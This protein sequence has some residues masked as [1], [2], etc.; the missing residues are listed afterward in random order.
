MHIGNLI[1]IETVTKLKILVHL[2][3]KKSW[4]VTFQK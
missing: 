3:L 1:L 4:Q 2:F